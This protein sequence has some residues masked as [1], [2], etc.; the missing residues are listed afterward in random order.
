MPAAVSISPMI[1]LIHNGR[2]EL[3]INFFT[4]SQV[5]RRWYCEELTA[6][7]ILLVTGESFFLD[8]GPMTHD[9]IMAIIRWS[10][11]S[12]LGSVTEQWVKRLISNFSYLMHL[13]VMAG[14]SFDS[15]VQYPLILNL[16]IENQP[17]RSGSEADSQCQKES[18]KEC[19]KGLLTPSTMKS[20]LRCPNLVCQSFPHHVRQAST[21]VKSLDDIRETELPA[22]FF[23]QP[24][25]FLDLKSL[26]EP[27]FEL[28]D[29]ASSAV[30]FVYQLRKCLESNSV[31]ESLAVWI[32][33]VFG[34]LQTADSEKIEILR[35][36]GTLPRRLFDQPHARRSITIVPKPFFVFHHNLSRINIKSAT[37]LSD[38]DFWILDMSGQITKIHIKDPDTLETETVDSVPKW[39]S[40]MIAYSLSDGFLLFESSSSLLSVITKSSLFDA[41]CTETDYFATSGT[42]F[43]SVY[44]RSFVRLMRVQQFPDSLAILS[45]TEDAIQCLA[46]SESF[47]VL[48]IV[49]RDDL[50]HFYSLKNL[51]QRFVAELPCS[52]VKRVVITPSW[53]FVCVEFG[54]QICAF[55]INAAF[56]GVYTHNSEISYWTAV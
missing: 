26:T 40:A 21:T 28:P 37:K 1:I 32:D 11:T 31:R 22:D 7:E 43:C 44:N 51:R 46:M 24:E 19:R 14:R 30:D 35:R 39:D 41:Q 6:V 56:L 42:S 29:R 25:L 53:G 15:F 49:T 18:D 54:K 10:D 17:R 55:A 45:V 33:S 4:I 52:S 23:F 27:D 8:F 5:Y 3:Q 36:C 2:R 34:C 47:H 12:E 9:A 20:S 48:V 38:S 16:L 50:L 13:N